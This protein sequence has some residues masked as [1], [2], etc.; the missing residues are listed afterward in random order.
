MSQRKHCRCTAPLRPDGTCVYKCPPVVKR[1][2]LSA[3]KPHASRK[4]PGAL[5]IALWLFAST[6]TA[7]ADET[8]RVDPPSA[9]PVVAKS[10]TTAESKYCSRTGEAIEDRIARL[11][12]A[13]R[14]ARAEAA[15]NRKRARK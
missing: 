2:V 4:A 6:R 10:A 8:P 11:E 13:L 3:S 12:T 1:R 9:P 5:A 7:G 14:L 15:V